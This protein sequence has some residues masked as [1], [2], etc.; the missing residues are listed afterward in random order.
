M[1]NYCPNVNLTWF[2]SVPQCFSPSSFPFRSS[3]SSWCKHPRWKCG[4][5]PI[6]P[7]LFPDFGFG[8]RSGPRSKLASI[9]KIMSGQAWTGQLIR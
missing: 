7:S 5:A 6:W 2:S 8:L 3:L 4:K 1:S 9:W